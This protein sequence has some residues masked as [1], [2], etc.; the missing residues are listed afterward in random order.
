MNGYIDN[1][2]FALINFIKEHKDN[3][4]ELLKK[5]PYNLKSIKNCF[6]NQ[7]WW[8]F[9]YNL[10]DSELTNEVVRNCRGVVL[11]INGDDVKPISVPYT[12]FFNYGQIE[13]KDLEDTINWKNA[14]FLIKEDGILTKTACVNEELPNGDTEKR[15][16]FFTN[17]SFDL[18]APFEDSL[19]F[20]EPE[21]RGAEFYGDLLE[22]ALKKIDASVAIH[23]DR[24][25]GQFYI[26]GGWSNN[27]PVG[28]T[29]M[30]EL[31]SP[32]NQIICK[33]KETKLI[34]HGYRK[35]D[36]VEIDPR[37]VDF[38]AKF[39]Y[40]E[41]LDASNFDDLQKLLSSFDG[42]EKEGCVVVDYSTEGVPRVKIKCDSYLKLKFARDTSCNSQVLFK[43]VVFDEYDDLLAA[44]PA[45]APKIN[46]IKENIKDFTS[47]FVSESLKYSE[48]CVK[49]D[50]PKAN[51][52]RWAMWCKRNVPKELFPYY[53]IMDG[54]DALV[55][56]EKRLERLSA[57]K[58]GYNI[59]CELLKITKA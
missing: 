42:N 43:A 46:E 59:L 4:E 58:H 16:Y 23:F 12:K 6:W 48:V 18:N 44:V 14:K 32:R 13:G 56:L 2:N 19:V 40:P 37:T 17:G 33:Y 27:V 57:V 1:K 49:G 15:L 7:S 24:E 45:T 52:K 26:T 51:K 8:M 34:L 41:L 38:G 50:D 10:F 55:R 39:E 5:E 31:V 20:D 53:M 3:W 29:L 9:V 11:S 21:T 54:F 36:L 22:I 35:P 47:W 30:F 25:F 28:S